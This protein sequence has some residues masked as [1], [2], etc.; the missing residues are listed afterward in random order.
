MNESTINPS[1]VQLAVSNGGPALTGDVSY[2]ASTRVVTLQPQSPLQAGTRYTATILGGSS[3]VKDL[4]GNA[5]TASRVWS[6]T[7]APPD[8][9]PPTITAVSPTNGTIGVARSTN[10]T[11]TFSEN[12]SATS[13]STDNVRLT[14]TAT[15]AL[16]PATVTYNASS[17]R[18][19]LNPNANLSALTLYRAEVIGGA[20]GPAD[21]AGNRLQNTMAWTFMTR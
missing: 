17:R 15:G 5:M 9:V 7:T 11:A 16:V 1:T 18:V 4:A 20:T 12:M 13:F 10:V 6:F 14:N 19:V 21:L 3:G 8:T 2:N